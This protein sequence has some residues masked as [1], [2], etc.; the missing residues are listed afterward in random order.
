[1]PIFEYFITALATF[2]KKE[3][4]NKLKKITTTTKNG[5]TA[6]WENQNPIIFQETHFKL[7]FLLSASYQ[8]FYSSE[9]VNSLK[10]CIVYIINIS[11][12][13]CSNT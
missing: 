5:K 12:S 9:L 6:E 1:M 11:Y 10:S 3:L 8:P 4:E 7:V 2:E 13:F